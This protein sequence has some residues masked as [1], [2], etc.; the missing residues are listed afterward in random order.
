MKEFENRVL[1]G[2]FGTKRDEIT[3]KWR[4]LHNEELSDLYSLPKIVLMIK[5]K[6]MIWAGHAACMG[7]RSGA[8]RVFGGGYL[9][10]RDHLKDPVVNGWIILKLIFKKWDVGAGNG[11]GWLMIRTGDRH[12]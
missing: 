8:C 2:I 5:F 1:R 4:K 6:R 9:R 12:L 10:K 7:E 3:A 11:S